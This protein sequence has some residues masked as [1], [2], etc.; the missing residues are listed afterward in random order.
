MMVRER[1]VNGRAFWLHRKLHCWAS[2]F[3]VFVLLV[4]RYLLVTQ[5]GMYSVLI[6]MLMAL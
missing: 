2:A 6:T 5:D 3:N 1:G 4:L